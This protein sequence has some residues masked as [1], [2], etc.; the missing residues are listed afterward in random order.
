MFS[1]R[2]SPMDSMLHVAVFILVR[3]DKGKIGR[4]YDGKKKRVITAIQITEDGEA[5]RI[6]AMKINDFFA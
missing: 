6:Y 3:K 5:K 1:S 4:S 2:N